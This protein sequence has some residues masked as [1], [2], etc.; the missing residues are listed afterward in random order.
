MARIA[1]TTNVTKIAKIAFK[2]NKNFH[3]NHKK[4][5]LTNIES[6]PRIINFACKRSY[7]KRRKSKKALQQYT[8]FAKIANENF[9]LLRKKKSSNKYPKNIITNL[10]TE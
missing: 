6:M 10:A 7:H 2:I 8:N 3:C 5:T 1:R 4:K 9:A